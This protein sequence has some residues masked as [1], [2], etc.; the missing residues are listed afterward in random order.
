MFQGVY[1]EA[2]MTHMTIAP[3]CIHVYLSKFYYIY[4]FRFRYRSPA[5]F[6]SI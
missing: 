1:F 4:I 3:S 5:P 2:L 6:G